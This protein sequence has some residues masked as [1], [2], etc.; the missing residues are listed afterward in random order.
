MPRPRPPRVTREQFVRAL[1]LHR[2]EGLAA[3]TFPPMSP[4][5]EFYL[6]L[7]ESGAPADIED[8][9]V[10][11]PLLLLERMTQEEAREREPE[12]ADLEDSGD[13]SAFS[14]PPEPAMPPE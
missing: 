10:S 11:E 2:L 13:G 4:R 1:Q 3:G 12:Q 14:L 6:R 9:V 8:F 7:V 5:E